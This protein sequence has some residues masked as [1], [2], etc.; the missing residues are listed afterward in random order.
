LNGSGPPR[1]RTPSDDDE[2]RVFKTLPYVK[3]ASDVALDASLSDGAFR[4]YV[5]LGTF[6]DI[7]QRDGFAGRKAIAERLGKTP[8]AVTRLMKELTDAG[9]ISRSE[10]YQD[11]PSGGRRRTTDE[12]ILLDKDSTVPA[13]RRSGSTEMAERVEAINDA[14]E[15]DGGDPWSMPDPTW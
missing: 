5:I 12:W 4:L 8:R 7:N 3:V 1:P 13:P 9:V 11:L 10:R 15:A 2:P 6:A 14:R